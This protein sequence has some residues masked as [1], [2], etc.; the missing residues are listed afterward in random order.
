MTSKTIQRSPNE[1]GKDGL[2]WV[3]ELLHHPSLKRMTEVSMDLLSVADSIKNVNGL[4]RV[5]GAAVSLLKVAQKYVHNASSPAPLVLVRLLGLTGAS[6]MNTSEAFSL[7]LAGYWV[8]SLPKLLHRSGL[9]DRHITV[10]NCADMLEKLG[11]EHQAHN[12]GD[13]FFH[14]F[15]HIW[16]IDLPSG[17]MLG[18]IASEVEDGI[19]CADY[20]GNV[21]EDG[22]NL[23]R[24]L[25]AL[26]LPM[27][28]AEVVM[29]LD[30]R[31][32]KRPTLKPVNINP[33]EY[34]VS[35]HDPVAFA[36]EVE[37]YRRAG[38]SDGVILEGLP[39][40]GK[41]SFIY[42]YA[43]LTRRTVLTI[44]SGALNDMSSG[45]VE[46][47]VDA[48]SPDVL[49]L[50]DFEYIEKRVSALF[51]TAIP[52]IRDR[53][54]K[55]LLVITCNDLMKIEEALT[56]P[57]RGGRTLPYFYAPNTDVKEAVFRLYL[58]KRVP[59]F[60][61]VY[62]VSA[63]VAEMSASLTQ[64]WIRS[65]AERCMVHQRV[66][67]A[68]PALAKDPTHSAHPMQRA[69]S[70]IQEA[71]KQVAR[72]SEAKKAHDVPEGTVAP[73]KRLSTSPVATAAIELLEAR[74]NLKKAVDSATEKYE[75]EV[76]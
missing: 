16:T 12:P 21:V 37:V 46:Q 63:L 52:D 49:M 69:L 71:N 56:R 74:M 23:L 18:R 14:G 42:S 38:V 4:L 26:V 76:T 1:R 41:T 7:V 40:T 11:Y 27:R 58:K 48:F 59:D 61:L 2:R 19:A 70:D 31:G 34:L 8:T 3:R 55:M 22:S 54:P 60:E 43:E 44:G 67:L 51:F 64:D 47:L 39:G 75:G 6:G 73:T 68:N 62:D 15:D 30:Y 28:S 17:R 10:H 20:N 50:D 9:L 53:H 24:E 13:G 57:G 29:A 25:V 36:D 33:V 66:L 32:Q 45:D 65:I 35:D 72:R 5:P